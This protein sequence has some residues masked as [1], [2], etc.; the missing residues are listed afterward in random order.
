MPTSRESEKFT[1]KGPSSTQ[2][3]MSNR[4]LSKEQKSK[5]IHN[6]FT[7]TKEPYTLPEIE[8]ASAVA[9]V[10]TSIVPI[11][12]TITFASPTKC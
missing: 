10:S 9:G 3:R 7:T 8:K 2:S 4:G 11:D 1:W 12:A 6:I 5:I